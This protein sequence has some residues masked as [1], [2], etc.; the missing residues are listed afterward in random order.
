[1][2]VFHTYQFSA[3]GSVEYKN[4]GFALQNIMN[5]GLILWQKGKDT[6]LR[7]WLLD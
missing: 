7:T 4:M 6:G 3:L 2:F 5:L 1:M